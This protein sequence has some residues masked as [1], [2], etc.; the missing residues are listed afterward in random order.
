MSVPAH[1]QQAPVRWDLRGEFDRVAFM[2]ERGVWID[3]VS[4]LVLAG[5][6]SWVWLVLRKG[7]EWGALGAPVV[8]GVFLSLSLGSWKLHRLRDR[9]VGGP[10]GPGPSSIGHL[11]TLASGP[12]IWMAVHAALAAQGFEGTRFH[13]RNT[14]EASLPG[15]IMVR[16]SL[17]VRVESA[18][19]GGAR[20]TA[21]AHPEIPRGPWALLIGYPHDG[22]AA[23]RTANGILRAIPGG[24]PVG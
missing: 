5:T 12:E 18:G 20:V 23:R 3:R 6:M 24:T 2:L 22:G 1:P 15:V 19:A 17:T 7:D 11:T 9:R 10:A 8:L 16:R 13:D 21:W 4:A 14:V